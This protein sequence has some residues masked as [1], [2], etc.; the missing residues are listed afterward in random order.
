MNDSRPFAWM[1]PN[2]HAH[3]RPAID[4]HQLS[5]SDF[6]QSSSPMWIYDQETLAFLEVNEA[7][8]SLYGYSRKE[9]LAMTI[10][11]IRP[12]EDIPMLLSTTMRPDQ[13]RESES[14][15]WRHAKKDGTVIDVEV[16]SWEVVFNGRPSELVSLRRRD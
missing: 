15:H 9:F 16:T 8:I 10:L 12:V 1:M 11:D 4:A 2:S 13:R 7:A 6:Y 14:E 3:E 5:Q